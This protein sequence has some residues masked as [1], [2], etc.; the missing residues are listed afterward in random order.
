MGWM[1]AYLSVWFE[2]FNNDEW[3]HFEVPTLPHL[4]LLEDDCG[5]QTLLAIEFLSLCVTDH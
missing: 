3:R 1:Y 5:L 4:K 2:A